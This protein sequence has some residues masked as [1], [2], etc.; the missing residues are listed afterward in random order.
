MKT[1]DIAE[2]AELY[3]RGTNVMAALRDGALDTNS[4]TALLYAYD[5]QSGSYTKNMEEPSFRALR[6]TIAARIA[7]VLRSLGATDVLE[8]G[9]GEAT[10]LA[11]VLDALGGDRQVAG[12]DISLSRLLYAR[13]VLGA[14]ADAVRLFTAELSDIPLPD[15]AADTVFTFHA[16][17]PNRGREE[18]I[19]RELL[20]VT[21]R[22]LVL[23]E[24]SY[25]IASPDARARM[26]R[27]GYVRDLPGA[28]AR[29]GHAPAR[30]EAWDIDVNPLNPAALSVVVKPGRPAS[31]G[32][33]ACVSPVSGKRL[34]AR[35][36]CLFC[37]EDGHAFPVI[38]GIPCLTAGNAVLCS[39]L[40]SEPD[41]R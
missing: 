14:R 35:A 31:R 40:G 22:N 5:L 9:V 12:F 37:P 30:H 6:A 33:D 20:R 29:L 11:P 16:L 28:L 7:D 25:E 27:L 23:V 1:Y 8:A 32:L 19:L 21:R 2:L 13:R 17:E 24:P 26:D 34:V 3:R 15:G 38:A 10:T 39:H 36:D 4:T 41:R 18:A